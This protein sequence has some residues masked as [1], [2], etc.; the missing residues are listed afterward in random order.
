MSHDENYLFN[1]LFTHGFCFKWIFRQSRFRNGRKEVEPQG[2][3]FTI[4]VE[5]VECYLYNSSEQ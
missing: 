1:F 5:E 4:P 2:N 3:P